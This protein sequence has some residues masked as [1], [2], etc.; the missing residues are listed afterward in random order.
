MLTENKRAAVM[1]ALQNK[2][3]ATT[4]GGIKYLCSIK[5]DFQLS[6]EDVAELSGEMFDTTQKEG[7]FRRNYGAYVTTE[8]INDEIEDKILQLKKE[9]IKLSDERIQ[10]NAYIRRLAREDTIKEIAAN[11]AREMG[12]KKLLDCPPLTS[13]IA[14]GENDAILCL[15]DWHWG[16]EIDNHANQ[17]NPDIAH[18]RVAQ[19]RDEVLK[20]SKLNKVETLYVLNLGDM[21]AGRIHLQLRLSSR[22]DVIEQTMQVSEVLAELLTDL[23]AH[24]KIEY[25]SC[26]DN[27]SRLEPNKKEAMDLESLCRITDWYLTDRLSDNANICINTDNLYGADIISFTC[28]GHLIGGTHGHYDKVATAAFKLNSYTH[29]DYDLICLAHRHH[30][31]AEEEC[32]TILACNSSLMGQDSY[33]HQL[34]L[35]S[36]P[37]QNLIITNE[38]HVMEVLYRIELD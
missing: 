4:E 18:K 32:R 26:L 19:L 7:Y 20:Y 35:D 6:W 13:K 16:I 33:A 3:F 37:S 14:A 38:K 31:A 9:R 21:I 29:N 28:R 23:S 11:F 27:H 2:D 36:K 25:Y 15:S 34:R 1:A 12:T 17:Y 5:R 22:M 30:F 24:F 8:E 10:N